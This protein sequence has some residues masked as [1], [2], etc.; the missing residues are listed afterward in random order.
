MK[1]LDYTRV[2][3]GTVVSEKSMRIN[4]LN[5]QIVLKVDKRSTKS[6]IKNAV[7]K[8]FEVKVKSVHVLNM[9]GKTK[10]AGR[11]LRKKPDWKKA[12][13]ILQPGYDID[14]TG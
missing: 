9:T 11:V 1:K 14:F 3:L 5:K 2:V 13:I 6:C 12:Y 7:E 4:E 8:L 10:R